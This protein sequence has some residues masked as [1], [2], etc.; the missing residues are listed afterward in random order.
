MIGTPSRARVAKTGGE[1]RECATASNEATGQTRGAVTG[2]SRGMGARTG[3]S[4]SKPPTNAP[5]L[6]RVTHVCMVALPSQE[7]WMV[8][9][10]DHACRELPLGAGLLPLPTTCQDG[11]GRDSLWPMGLEAKPPAERTPYVVSSS[12]VCEGD[13]FLPLYQIYHPGEAFAI[14]LLRSGVSRRSWS[15]RRRTS[16]TERLPSNRLCKKSMAWCACN[17]SPGMGT[18]PPPIS[19]ASEMV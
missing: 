8:H 16:T 3:P 10:E 7:A 18:C 9:P 2:G 17:T 4:R 6:M 12:L 11:R 1:W 19:P 5:A 13:R 14:A 15:G